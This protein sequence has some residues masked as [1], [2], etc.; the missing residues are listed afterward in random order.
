M[1][2]TFGRW[3]AAALVVC[4]ALGTAILPADG[5]RWIPSWWAADAPMRFRG[6]YAR[7]NA[8]SVNRYDA[9]KEFVAARDL[10]SARREF[11]STAG[12]SGPPDVRFAVNVPPA[13]RAAFVNELNGERAERTGWKD[14]GKVGVLV[15]VDSPL[16]SH[17]V[18]ISHGTAGPTADRAISRVIAPSARTGDRCVVQI[19][20]P[21]TNAW[22]KGV[23]G[24]PQFAAQPVLDA[25]G[26]YD[27]FGPPGAAIA[28]ELV[29]SRFVLTRGY[30]TADHDDPIARPTQ[31]WP[32]IWY[33]LP[34]AR[35]LTGD[36]GG[37]WSFTSVANRSLRHDPVP[38]EWPGGSDEWI[39]PRSRYHLS[40]IN[41]LALE[42]GPDRFAR[43]WKSSKTLEDAYFDETGERWPDYVRRR[44]REVYGPYSPGPWTTVLS[45]ALT[46]LTVV[47][48]VGGTLRFGERPRVA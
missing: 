44:D 11:G 27:A 40:A 39:L 7:M 16:T 4:L 24:E 38:A 18:I 37:C 47:V 33:D 9:F 23:N 36:D 30:V 3:I 31:T 34:A 22:T 48:L 26:F 14:R 5:A 17:G 8:R 20:L 28:R 43:I 2:I 15:A 13:L 45:L 32:A 19:I 46:L 21:N 25:C 41:R 6:W 1:K 10:V 29:E 12:M 35:C 42:L